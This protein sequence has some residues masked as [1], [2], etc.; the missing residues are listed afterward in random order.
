MTRDELIAFEKDMAVAFGRGEIKS[1]LHLAGGNEDELIAIFERIRPEDWICCSWRSHLHALLKGVPPEEVKAAILRGRSIALCFP[2]YKMI[3]SA[4]VGGNCS[5]A[6]GLA[7][8][9]RRRGS[10]E[11][12]WCFIGDM[13]AKS[14]IAREAMDFAAGHCLPVRFVVEDN[15]LS[16]CTDTRAAW[17]MDEGETFQTYRYQL[18]YPHVGI[19]KFVRF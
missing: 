12:V 15:G 8:G 5:L 17:G 9:A 6:V 3:S 10:D 19:G 13:T 18:G 14:G 11:R 1:P 4:I 2:Q 16:V 7:L